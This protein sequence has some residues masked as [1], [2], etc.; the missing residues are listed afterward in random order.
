[1]N[2]DVQKVTQYHDDPC[3]TVTIDGNKYHVNGWADF[4]IMP[5]SKND[6]GY[7]GPDT[8]TFTGWRVDCVYNDQL[9]RVPWITAGLAF[10]AAIAMELELQGGPEWRG[11]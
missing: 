8:V 3:P 9:Q 4:E 2:T 1:M 5:D 7:Q 10:R 6:E 11:F